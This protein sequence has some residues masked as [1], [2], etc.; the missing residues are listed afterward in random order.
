LA[1]TRRG[2]GRAGRPQ[3]RFGRQAKREGFA[4]RSVYKLE[5]IDRRVHLLRPGARVLDL[6]ASPGSW[7]Q[8]AADR[9]GPQGVVH[10]VDQK[11]PGVD[12]PP[13]VRWT[14]ADVETLTPEELGGPASFDVVLSDMAPATS[15]HKSV[16]QA[17]SFRLFI[18]ALTLARGTLAPGGRFCGKI[19]QSGEFPE[20]HRQVREAFDK[21]RIL[22]PKA[23][24]TES[25]EVYLIGLSLVP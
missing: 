17:R 16:D 21:A 14:H 25:T 11:D 13:W 2:R 9:V 1:R 19:F 10:A 12:L 5:E 20:A 7:S 18:A 22:R 23:I 3:D 24:R 6:G 15:G 8:Y 4:A